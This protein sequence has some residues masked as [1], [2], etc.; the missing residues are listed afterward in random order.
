VT[1]TERR[2]ARA[3]RVAERVAAAK[4]AGTYAPR[5]QIRRSHFRTV[6][7]R[8]AVEGDVRAMR[9]QLAARRNR[10]PAELVTDEERRGVAK[11]AQAGWAFDLASDRPTTPETE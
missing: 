8:D 7:I 5:P 1:K 6:D 3:A 11:N 4:A 9:Q 10:L 2:R